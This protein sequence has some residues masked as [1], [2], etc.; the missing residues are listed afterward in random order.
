MNNGYNI[1]HYTVSIILGAFLLVSIL[2]SH[3]QQSFSQNETST[4][5][6]P[7]SIKTENN[8]V[9]IFSKLGF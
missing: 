5:T 8:A 3:Q 9:G 7:I 2:S 6:Q 4:T 1:N